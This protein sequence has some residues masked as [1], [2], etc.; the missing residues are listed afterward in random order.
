[1]GSGSLI[2]HLIGDRSLYQCKIVTYMVHGAG[3]KIHW[4]CYFMEKA[5]KRSLDSK[6]RSGHDH[7]MHIEPLIFSN[8]VCDSIENAIVVH[9]RR[10]S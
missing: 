4:Y 5:D 2:T 7:Q 8:P 1:M 10:L 6:K 9:T 3:I